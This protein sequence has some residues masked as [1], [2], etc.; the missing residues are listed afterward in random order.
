[1][2]YVSLQGEI[3]HAGIY[4]VAPGETLRVMSWSA[5]GGLT[6]KAYLYGSEF[7]RESTQRLQQE[8]LNEYVNSLEQDIALA[9]GNATGSLSSIPPEQQRWER[10]C[11]VNGI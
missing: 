10:A 7:L 11:K 2:K 6:P 3:V 4:S 5:R 8:R 1:M 9:A